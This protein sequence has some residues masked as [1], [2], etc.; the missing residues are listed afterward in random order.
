M[1]A[2]T[3]L[4]LGV[5]ALAI[6][7]AG[8]ARAADKTVSVQAGSAADRSFANPPAERP[9]AETPAATPPH[10]TQAA[11]PA[12]AWSA[13]TTTD[14]Y[15]DPRDTIQYRFQIQFTEGVIYNPWTLSNDKVR[16]R[17]YR[18]AQ[19][20]PKTPF[21]APT[22]TMRPGQTVRISLDNELLDLGPDGKPLP[23]QPCVHTDVNVPHCFN[24]TNL[25]SHG[26]WVSPTGN[27]DNVLISI[28]PGVIFDYE[29]NVPPDHPAGTFWYHPHKHGS[30]AL[31]VSSGMDGALIIRG[32]RPP[33]AVTP[34]DIDILLTDADNRA[35]A[36]KVLLFQQVQ[37]ACFDKDGKIQT[38]IGPDGKPQRPWVCHPGQVGE[39]RDYEQQFSPSSTWVKS[40]R[41]TSINGVVQ[42]MISGLKA[43]RFERWRLIHGGVREAVDFSI[44][45]QKAGAP[46]FRTVKA[47]DQAAWMAKYCE[48]TRP[49]PLFEIALDGLT[50]QAVRRAADTRLQPGYRADLAVSFPAGG[51]YCIVDAAAPA[52]GSPSQLAEAA[53]VLAIAEVQDT[54]SAQGVDPEAALRDLM[55][56]AAKRNIPAG[57]TQDKVVA[58]LATL[59]LS[60]FVWHKTIDKAE[61]NAPDQ[62]LVFNI[63]TQAAPI[64]FEVNG[65]PY[66]P[67]RID[68]QLKLGDVQEWRLSSDFAAHPFH[69]HVNPFQIV[70]VKTKAGVDVTDPKGGAF[71]ADYAGL[72]GQWKDTLFVKEGLIIAT[73]TRYERYIGEFV[74]HCHILDHED[75]GMMQNVSIGIPDGFGGVATAHGRAATPHH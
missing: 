74:L 10:L 48:L 69:I 63:D 28:N 44:F 65:Q 71:D 20:D 46:D 51:R 31:Q 34:G 24:Q 5:A 1:R 62:T 2:R 4:L 75:Q 66:D 8:A 30:T 16:L 45:P 13:L 22:I 12:A 19:V 17:S 29:Y 58:D 39:I 72:I 33:T 23:P 40:G 27:S 21:L 11:T 47:A 14:S 6:A 50:R 61:L 41:F 9:E 55:V 73:R 49:L 59:T 35:I 68:R 57:P 53:R 15:V 3:Y 56:A 26:L 37:Y 18:G 25:H 54:P 64:R 32:D 67:A 70:S 60:A 42:P 7:S 38:T 52:T 43:G 36:D